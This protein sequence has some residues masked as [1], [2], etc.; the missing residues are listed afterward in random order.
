[1]PYG[2]SPNSLSTRSSYRRAPYRRRAAVGVSAAAIGRA[3]SSSVNSALRSYM[4]RSSQTVARKL[5]MQYKRQRVVTPKRK[6][7]TIGQYRGKFKRPRSHKYSKRSKNAA[8]FTLEHGGVLSNADCVYVGH[9]MA[10]DKLVEAIAFSHIKYL[11]EKAGVSCNNAEKKI[12]GDELATITTPFYQIVIN[13][14]VNDQS[15]VLLTH[16][17]DIDPNDTFL[18]AASKY[19]AGLYAMVIASDEE[20]YILGVQL[21]SQEIATTNYRLVASM[22]MEEAYINLHFSSKMNVQ[23]QTLGASGSDDQITD[24]TNNPL[25]G[26]SYQGWGTGLVTT[27]YNVGTAL[28]AENSMSAN[29]QTGLIRFDPNGTNVTTQMQAIYKRPPGVSAFQQGVKSTNIRVPAGSIKR[30]SISYSKIFKFQT[31]FN[32]LLQDLR[33]NTQFAITKIG[34]CEVLALQKLCRTG[35]EQNISVGYEINQTYSLSMFCRKRP[36][37]PTHVV[38]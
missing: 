9:A 35:A 32:I 30:S 37:A 6:Y 16:R 19:A 29:H 5:P 4:S 15:G 23:N 26:K 13:H 14:K 25:E 2:R 20:V 34:K 17:V 24:V 28:T 31:L 18:Q 36:M 3:V 27:A 22:Q 12:N 33:V 38:L 8:T 7:F 21:Q 11:F 10:T 1:M